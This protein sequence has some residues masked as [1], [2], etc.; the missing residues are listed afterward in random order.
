MLRARFV[1]QVCKMLMKE[2]MNANPALPSHRARC[3]RMALN[4]SLNGRS[5]SYIKCFCAGARQHQNVALA[6]A[7]LL[8]FVSKSNTLYHPRRKTVPNTTKGQSEG[9][10]PLLKKALIQE[11]FSS[12]TWSSSPIPKSC[13]ASLSVTSGR[14]SRASH[15]M[16]Y[17]P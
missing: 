8:V 13:P 1:R 2:N 9:E 17:L 10:C 7:K 5:S 12:N 15:S 16:E 11:P 3:L 14:C 6:L 4:L